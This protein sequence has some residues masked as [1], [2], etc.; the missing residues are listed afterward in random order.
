MLAGLTACVESSRYLGAPEAPVRQIPGIFTGERDALGDALV[1]DVDADLGEPVDIAFARAE[2]AAFDRVVEQA[3]HAIAVVLVILGGIDPALGG[4]AVG[5][6]WAVL[7]TERFDVVT[8]LT[9]GG[10]RRGSSQTGADDDDVVFP[11]VGRIDKLGVAP[12]LIPFLGERSV[13]NAGIEL[14]VI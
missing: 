9:K 7:N 2:V 3:V 5:A 10:C 11:F 1:D 12:K 4:N 8:E 6:A 13:G 14:H